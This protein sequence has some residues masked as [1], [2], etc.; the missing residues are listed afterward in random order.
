VGDN[1]AGLREIRCRRC[2]KWF[3]VDVEV[4]NR[5]HMPEYCS[6]HY[7]RTGLS[8]VENGIRREMN[9]IADAVGATSPKACGVN[10]GD[11]I[12]PQR[13]MPI[14]AIAT[15]IVTA[16]HTGNEQIHVSFAPRGSGN[17]TRLPLRVLGSV[18]ARRAGPVLVVEPLRERAL[19]YA[20]VT[21]N[22]YYGLSTTTR[23][24]PPLFGPYLA[25]GCEMQAC[26]QSSWKNLLIYATEGVL[27]RQ[28]ERGVIGRYSVVVLG[29][30][31]THV[32]SFTRTLK[33]LGEAMN[34]YP[35]L[36]VLIGSARR[37]EDY[38]LQLLGKP[39][40]VHRLSPRASAIEHARAV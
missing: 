25:V 9:R 18:D 20:G 14:D 29:D 13:R 8:S 34:R 35:L 39:V 19:K 7:Y 21:G 16:L 4:L 28:I 1:L 23:S 37:D 33:L 10:L 38:L 40:R 22:S 5:T 36:K 27:Q 6:Q 24:I 26:S 11:L 30:R 12:A 3:F 17:S 31:T 15:E 32:D 2:G